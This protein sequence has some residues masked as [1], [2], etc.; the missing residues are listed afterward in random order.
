MLSYFYKAD[1]GYGQ[2]ICKVLNA[3]VAEV[4][5][6]GPAARLSLPA[7]VGKQAQTG[8]RQATHRWQ[9]CH[10]IAIVAA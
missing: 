6:L 3:N 5:R 1:S 9:P 4:A 2:A 10:D 8:C 7:P